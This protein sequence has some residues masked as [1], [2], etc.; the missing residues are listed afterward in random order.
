MLQIILL[1]LA[2]LVGTL[3]PQLPAF[4]LHNPAAYA[5]A[6]ADMAQRYESLSVLG[7]NIGPQ[8][9][10]VFERVGFFRVFSAP[11]FIFLLTL[12]VVS[13]TVCTLDRTPRLWRSVRVVKPAQPPAFFDPHSLKDTIEN[14]AA[15]HL[16]HVVAALDEAGPRRPPP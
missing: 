12:L 16:D 10:D 5:D 14:F 1:V 2:G 6:M 11:W 7:L 15:V 8:M 4:T 13:I 3:V 9:V